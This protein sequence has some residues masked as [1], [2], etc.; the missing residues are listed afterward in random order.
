LANFD[1]SK[2]CFQRISNGASYPLLNSKPIRQHGAVKAVNLFG[3]YLK[4]TIQTDPGIQSAH[5]LIKRSNKISLEGLE[6]AGNG[7]MM[8]SE[9]M[10]SA[11][12]FH[13]H[14]NTYSQ[15]KAI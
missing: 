2:G 8:K 15:G 13:Q 12:N 5:N 7:G 4:E 9:D 3:S 11:E 14:R 10:H 6:I 1:F